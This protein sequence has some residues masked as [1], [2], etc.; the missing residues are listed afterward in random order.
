M[1]L[2]AIL[3]TVICSQNDVSTAYLQNDRVLKTLKT[4]YVVSI[5]EICLFFRSCLDTF[6]LLASKTIEVFGF[7]RGTYVVGKYHIN[8]YPVEKANH[9][10]AFLSCFAVSAN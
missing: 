2:Y 3:V 10:L 9:L 6:G 7:L 8:L 5:G 1:F 4:V